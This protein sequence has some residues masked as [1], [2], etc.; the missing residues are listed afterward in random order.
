MIDYSIKS[1]DLST[2]S[3]STIAFKSVE[4]PNDIAN[5][6]HQVM[7][8]QKKTRVVYSFTKSRSDFESGGSKPYKQKGTGRARQGSSRSPLKVGGAVIF[9]PK[10][11]FVQR[12]TNKRVLIN[13][14]HHLLL[15]KVSD[16]KVLTNTANVTKAK[17][18]ASLLDDKRIYLV[19]VDVASSDDIQFFSRVKNIPNLYFA[20]CHSIN[21]EDA[22]RADS[23]L[24]TNSAFSHLFAVGKDVSHD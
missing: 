1:D 16:S 13:T 21:F 22:I 15:S 6:L 12:K 19:I 20:N 7:N 2:R 17:Q 4:I 9:G 23:I 5:K 10:P 8:N 18:L 11:R 3:T 14:L 24:Y